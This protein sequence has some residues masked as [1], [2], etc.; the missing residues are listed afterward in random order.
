MREE[1]LLLV[2][3]RLLHLLNLLGGGP[4]TRR[5]HHARHH[6]ARHWAVSVSWGAH[7]WSLWVHAAW[8]RHAWSLHKEYRKNVFFFLSHKIS[9]KDF[10]KS[11]YSHQIW[12]IQIFVQLHWGSADVR[13]DSVL[14]RILICRF[15]H[16]S[17]IGSVHR[18]TMCTF[19]KLNKLKTNVLISP[20]PGLVL[21]VALKKN[22]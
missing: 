1:D 9:L 15:S 8:R 14:Y 13:Q 7:G 6:R 18:H 2:A 5:V 11:L 20:I 16:T 4:L 3:V 12:R 21:A 22:Q 17:G 10:H 19:C